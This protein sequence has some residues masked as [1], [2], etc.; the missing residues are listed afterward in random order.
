MDL[1]KTIEINKLFDF[2]GVLLTEKQQKVIK[3]YYF[4]NI[5]LSEIS[6]NLN[7]SRQAVR[8]CLLKAE[9]ALKKFECELGLIKIYEKQQNIV[10]QMQKCC[11]NSLLK[12]I[13]AVWEK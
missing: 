9:N 5:S 2:Y 6:E 10:E 12:Q 3:D 13:L 7:I 8:D 11:D 1:V 4:Y